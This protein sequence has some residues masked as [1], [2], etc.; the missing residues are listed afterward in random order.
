MI[1]TV[2]EA[3]VPRE[4]RADLVR[5]YERIVAGRSHVVVQ[6]LLLCCA[7]DDRYWRIT[8]LQADD[9]VL[10]EEMYEPASVDVFRS[11]GI[12]PESIS[13]FRIVSHVHGAVHTPRD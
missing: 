1:V 7:R 5:H 4:K 6:T 2:V 12:E 8:T 9:D 11:V 13:H 3:P 10:D